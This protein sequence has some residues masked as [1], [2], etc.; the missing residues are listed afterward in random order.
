MNPT[1]QDFAVDIDITTDLTTSQIRNAFFHLDSESIARTAT[2]VITITVT[3][4]E[5]VN[6]RPQLAVYDYIL[7]DVESGDPVPVEL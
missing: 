4:A 6:M 7:R 2:N 3:Y 5:Y 1:N